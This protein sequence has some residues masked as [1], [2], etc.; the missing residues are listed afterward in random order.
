MESD[1]FLKGQ[2]AGI[3][4]AQYFQHYGKTE[5]PMPL[6]SQERE[7]WQDGYNSGWNCI[8]AA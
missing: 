7:D 8:A 2:E 1:A 6:F 3:N 4:D 5:N